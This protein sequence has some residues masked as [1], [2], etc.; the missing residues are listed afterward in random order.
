MFG[1]FFNTAGYRRKLCLKKLKEYDEMIDKI[2]D[3]ELSLDYIS[4]DAVPAIKKAMVALEK[5]A[6]VFALSWYAAYYEPLEKEDKRQILVDRNFELP[7]SFDID[8]TVEDHL[9]YRKGLG[10]VKGILFGN[11]DI[12]GDLFDIEVLWKKKL[13]VVDEVCKNEKLSK[14]VKA[15]ATNK[16]KESIDC[17]G[18]GRFYT[19]LWGYTPIGS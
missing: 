16:Y 6:E 10:L 1:K 15:K 9:F 12:E 4:E 13:N 17:V 14:M 11:E 2:C 18:R 7:W 19:K 5:Q 8:R 3:A